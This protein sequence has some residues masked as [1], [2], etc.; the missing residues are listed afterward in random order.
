MK[1]HPIAFSDELIPK[2]LDGTKTVTRRVINPQPRFIYT[3][4]GEPWGFAWS[5]PRANNPNS[6]YF[7]MT[8]FG[9]GDEY[10]EQVLKQMLLDYSIPKYGKAGEDQLWVKEAWAYLDAEYKPAN[11]LSS[12]ELR[13][14]HELQ[15]IGELVYKV[16]HQSDNDGPDEIKWRNRRFMP[17]W[18]SRADLDVLDIR[19]E[20]VNE[21]TEEDALA[22]GIVGTTAWLR[23]RNIYE[24]KVETFARLWDMMHEKTEFSWTHNPWVF[25]IEFKLLEK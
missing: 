25:R 16:D 12:K 22:E 19:A 3:D 13:A 10:D 24:P 23:R 5:H 6:K 17:K 14:F 8:N 7:G 11:H 18:A 15:G 1:S 20:R 9:K 2:V 4:P 21:I